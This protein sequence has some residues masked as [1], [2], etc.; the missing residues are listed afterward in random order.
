MHTRGLVTLFDKSWVEKSLWGHE[1]WSVDVD[2]LSIR[3][4][5]SLLDFRG[6]SSLGL[7]CSRVKRDK[8]EIDEAL[9]NL[10]RKEEKRNQYKPHLEELD[11]MR[12]EQELLT[13]ALDG[14]VD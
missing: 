9:L 3:K 13:Q 1:S 4:L 7:I 10:K 11:G 12:G 5:I 14:L 2:S 8:A 6:L